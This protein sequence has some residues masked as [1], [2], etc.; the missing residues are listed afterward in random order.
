MIHKF[1]FPFES[2]FILGKIL[3]PNM[4]YGGEKVNKKE[5]NNTAININNGINL[6]LEQ[7][8]QQAKPNKTPRIANLPQGNPA[9]S[10]FLNP[11]NTE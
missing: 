2:D 4:Q 1:S 9:L 8:N 10:C 5:A 7:P 3:T 11:K 6:N